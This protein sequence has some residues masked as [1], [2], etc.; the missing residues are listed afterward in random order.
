MEDGDTV[1]MK[2]ALLTRLL[3]ELQKQVLV[4]SLEDNNDYHYTKLVD[5]NFKIIVNSNGI[6]GEFQQKLVDVV[7]SN[8][9]S[10]KKFLLQ[11][12]SMKY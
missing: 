2:K 7:G 8:A 10:S 12:C 1:I 6:G 5:D 4:G 9:S 11:I 3:A